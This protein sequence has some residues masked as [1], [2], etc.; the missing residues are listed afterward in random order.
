M[1][2]FFFLSRA[3]HIN[4]ASDSR[5][6]IALP[7]WREAHKRGERAEMTH[8]DCKPTEAMKRAG[9]KLGRVERCILLTSRTAFLNEYAES[10][11]ESESGM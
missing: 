8:C 11:S 1:I 3:V 10:E 7:C 6:L 2:G 4:A 9:I 5:R